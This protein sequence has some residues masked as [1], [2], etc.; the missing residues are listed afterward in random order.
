MNVRRFMTAFF[1][2]TFAL[3][4][5]HADDKKPVAKSAE[6][7][8]K[9]LTGAVS[10]S[11]C[12]KTHMMPGKSAA[13]CAKECAKDGDYALV[14]GSKVYTLKGHKDELEKFAGE[15]ATV[16]GKVTGTTVEVASVAAAKESPAKANTMKPAAKKSM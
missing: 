2:L 12:G 16:T 15:N 11:M 4:V 1:A 14:V 6:G 13:E 10:D 5:A 3:A 8:T 7:A 9:T